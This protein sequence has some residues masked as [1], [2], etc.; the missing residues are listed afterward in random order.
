MSRP[1]ARTALITGAA[2]GLGRALAHALADEGMQ[3]ALTDLD[4]EGL[5]RVG[6]EV[7]ARGARAHRIAADL[8]DP[9]QIERLAAS[10]IEALGGIDLLF[11]NAGI[12]HLG[13]TRAMSL[14]QWEAILSVNLW[15]PIRLTHALMPHLIERG[16]GHIVNIASIA[17]LVALPGIAAYCTTKFAIVGYSHALRQELRP[18]GVTVSVACPGP[19]QT[20]LTQNA[21]Y[22]NADARERLVGSWIARDG[23]TASRAAHEILRGMRSGRA[24]ILVT[25]AAHLLSG[26]WRLAPA[27]SET[28]IERLWPRMS[29]AL[30]V[31]GAPTASSR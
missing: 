26:F 10:A 13:E 25:P 24:Q 31:V 7:E 12:V 27:M 23:Y 15:A 5:E 8:R 19:V 22:V 30:G 29:R 1:A 11:N 3:I 6:R 20:Q 9:A 2:S 18:H 21:T 16:G 14:E 4:L 17:G 28:V